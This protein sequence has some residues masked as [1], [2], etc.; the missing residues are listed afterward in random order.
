ML[1]R[2]HGEVF[3]KREEINEVR[4]Q[5]EQLKEERKQALDEV[6]S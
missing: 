2:V 1:E 5:I 4:G 6:Y 3:E